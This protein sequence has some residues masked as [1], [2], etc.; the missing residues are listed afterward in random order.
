MAA[1][2]ATETSATEM[3]VISANTEL[4]LKSVQSAVENGAVTNRRTGVFKTGGN[5][6]WRKLRTIILRK[7]CG[8]YTVIITFIWL[9]YTL[10]IIF[11]FS[12]NA[13]VSAMGFSYAFK[14]VCLKLQ[15]NSNEA[16]RINK[17]EVTG[18]AFLK[19]VQNFKLVIVLSD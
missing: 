12:I 18:I 13:K 15:F 14:I 11:Y 10:P 3:S 9:L 2:Q 4:E 5:K 8:V 1:S 17:T 6:K 16:D 19:C 7:S